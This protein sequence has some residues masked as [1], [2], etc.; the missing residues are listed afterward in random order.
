LG[1]MAALA[2]GQPACRNRHAQ[3]HW[4]PRKLKKYSISNIYTYLIIKIL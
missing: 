4:Q 1:G 3:H 2:H